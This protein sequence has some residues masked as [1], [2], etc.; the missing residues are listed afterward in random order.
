MATPSSAPRRATDPRGFSYQQTMLRVKDGPAAVAFYERHF[1]MTLVDVKRFPEMRFDLYFLAT[2]PE[3]ATA[4]PPGTPESNRFLWTFDRTVLELTHNYDDDKS[5][6][7]RYN[8]GNVEPHRG[9]GHIGFIVDDLASFCA[10]LEAA[11]VQFQKRLTEGRMRHIAFA[12]D[13]D[14][15]WVEILSRTSSP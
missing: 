15:Y 2:L 13:V 3:G 8:N 10:G 1:G 12:R 7:F 11:G 5:P 9:F 6:G 14:G 4:P